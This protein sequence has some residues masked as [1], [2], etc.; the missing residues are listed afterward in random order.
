MDQL[1]DLPAGWE[2]WNAEDRGQVVLAYRPDVF[3]AEAFP[4]ACLP[5]LTV[6]PGPSPEARPEVRAKADQWHVALYLEPDVQVRAVEARFDDREAAVNGAV[7]VA[8]AFAADQVDYR[9]AYLK[10]REDYLDRLD[11]LLGGED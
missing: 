9:E 6:A 4:P 1:D 7:D 2:V 10:P 11:E 8:R 5:T 3:N